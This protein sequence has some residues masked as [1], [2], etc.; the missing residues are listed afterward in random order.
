LWYFA[1]RCHEDVTELILSKITIVSL[2]LPLFMV[3]DQFDNHLCNGYR[4]SIVVC[5]LKL[6]DSFRSVFVSLLFVCLNR[7]FFS[8]NQTASHIP[9]KERYCTLNFIICKIIMSGKTFKRCQI[10]TLFYE[11]SS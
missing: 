1:F 9:K 7:W 3:F 11:V 6:L 2:S 10:M 8:S 5:I 4:C